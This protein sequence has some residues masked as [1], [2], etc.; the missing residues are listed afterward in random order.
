MNSSSFTF[1]CVV[2]KTTSTPHNRLTL[3]GAVQM[4]F[5]AGGSD[6]K[7]KTAFFQRKCELPWLSAVVQGGLSQ[8]KEMAVSAPPQTT[9]SYTTRL[10]EM[11]KY[12]LE[13]L[14]LY[15]IFLYVHLLSACLI[16]TLA[17]C[18]QKKWGPVCQYGH[19]FL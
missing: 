16:F 12:S 6:T 10:P 18:S 8:P 5:P 14:L 2:A 13:Y 15:F 19:M 9:H 4:A 7:I 11:A 17:T 3:L 1:H